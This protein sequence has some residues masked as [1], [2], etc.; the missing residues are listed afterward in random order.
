VTKSMKKLLTLAAACALSVCSGAG[1]EKGRSSYAWDPDLRG[2]GAS[3]PSPTEMRAYLTGST[4]S[5]EGLVNA[6]M[7]DSRFDLRLDVSNDIAGYF[8][9]RS[10]QAYDKPG[11][12]MRPPVATNAVYR[13]AATFRPDLNQ[14]EEYFE[15]IG[16][17]LKVLS[18]DARGSRSPREVTVW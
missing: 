18:T 1:P 5:V 6:Q 10:Y 3:Y 17:S 13:F 9:C 2:L 11:S 12:A 4:N 16:K 14:L 7:F 8:G 15:D